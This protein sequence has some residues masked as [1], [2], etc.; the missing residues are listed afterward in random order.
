LIDIPQQLPPPILASLAESFALYWSHPQA[1]AVAI[2]TAIEGIADHLGQ[3]RQVKGKFVP[4]AQRLKNLK[5]QHPDLFKAAAAI[6]DFVNL[7]AHGDTVDR[8]NLLT[9]YELVEIELRVLFEDTNSR[10]DALIGKL[11]G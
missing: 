8:E 4:L 7:G 5:P 10:R 3:P 6:K 1:C 9:A 2:R 11:K